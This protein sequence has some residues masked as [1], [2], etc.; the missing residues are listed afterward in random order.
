MKVNLPISGFAPFKVITALLFLTSFF[1]FKN[2]MMWL[3]LITPPVV[4]KA[5]ALGAWIGMWRAGKLNWEYVSYILIFLSFFTYMG[6]KVWTL[7][8]ITL[9]TSLLFTVHFWVSLKFQSTLLQ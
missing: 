6:L 3:V 7:G 2:F 4:G 5:H 1:F 9:F 8:E